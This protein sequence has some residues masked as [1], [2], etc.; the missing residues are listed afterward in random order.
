MP[1]R[2]T[3]TIWQRGGLMGATDLGFVR[4]VLDSA[5]YS[6]VESE[7]ES[8]SSKPIGFFSNPPFGWESTILCRRS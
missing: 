6:F 5:D 3:T 8:D 7:L 2:I 1:S 4:D